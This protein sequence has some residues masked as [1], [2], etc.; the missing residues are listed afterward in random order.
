MAWAHEFFRL[1]GSR[2]P[3]TEEVFD[4][5]CIMPT[6]IDNNNTE[7]KAAMVELWAAEDAAND[8]TLA[9]DLRNNADRMEEESNAARMQVEQALDAEL[10]FDAFVDTVIDPGPDT[11]MNPR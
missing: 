5:Q 2:I 6:E 10:M 11:D 9:L 4:W 1:G 8:A 3:T 7:Y